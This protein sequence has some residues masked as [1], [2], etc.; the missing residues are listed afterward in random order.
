MLKS[1]YIGLHIQRCP[2]LLHLLLIIMHWGHRRHIIGS[3]KNSFLTD[4]ELATLFVAFCEKSRFINEASL[5]F[6]FFRTLFKHP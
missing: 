1:A 2:R 4:E 5:S 6:N 3:Y